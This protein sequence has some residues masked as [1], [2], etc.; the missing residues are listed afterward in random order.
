MKRFFDLASLVLLLLMGVFAVQSYPRLPGR[1]PMHFNAAGQPDRWGGKEGLIVLF[2]VPAVMTAVLYLLVAAAPRL[3]QNARHVNIP[4][5]AEFLKLPAEK[6]A[7]YW[8]LYKEFFAALAASMNLLF[9][10][11]IRGSVEVALGSRSLLPLKAG[12]PALALM[13]VLMIFYFWRLMTVPGK[14]IR[15]EE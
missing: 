4:H 6:Q 7:V 9:Y 1:V 14:L 12:L 2:A 8:A 5:R 11:F 10:I 3:G 13:G 15:G